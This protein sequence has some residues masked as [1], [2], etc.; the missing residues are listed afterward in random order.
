MCASPGSGMNRL[1]FSFVIST[2]AIGGC[3]N[4]GVPEEA[5]QGEQQL[6]EDEE[7]LEAIREVVKDVDEEHVVF[8][9]DMLAP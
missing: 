3:S 7:R 4:V 9:D 2:A 5:A 1:L 6:T 8:A